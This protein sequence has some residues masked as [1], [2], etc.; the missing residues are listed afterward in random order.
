METEVHKYLSI[1]THL[2]IPDVDDC[3]KSNC[4][5]EAVCIDGINN[6]T[7]ACQAGFTGPSCNSSKISKIKKKLPFLTEIRNY[8]NLS[9][10]LCS[11]RAISPRIEYGTPLT[12]GCEC[13]ML[14]SW[15]T[16][17]IE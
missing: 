13:T 15:S 14:I 4:Q 8:D 2:T 16:L 12:H 9:T 11:N 7:C 10:N 3:P 5:N 6:F 1:F 17:V